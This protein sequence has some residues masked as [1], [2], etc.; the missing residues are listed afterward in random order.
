MTK[1]TEF[2]PIKE[3]ICFI[4]GE[5]LISVSVFLTDVSNWRTNENTANRP[6]R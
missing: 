4:I 6:A 2:K 5:D 1:Y 3:N